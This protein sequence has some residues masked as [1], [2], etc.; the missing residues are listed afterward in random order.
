VDHGALP[1][2]T[3]PVCSLFRSTVGRATYTFGALTGQPRMACARITK[4]AGRS[5]CA[6]LGALEVPTGMVRRESRRQLGLGHPA[7]R[8]RGFRAEYRI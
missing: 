8:A 1:M 6:G 4:A 7:I 2:R 5:S 3:S